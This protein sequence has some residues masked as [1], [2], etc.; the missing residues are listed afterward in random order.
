MSPRLVQIALLFSLAYG[1]VTSNVTCMSTFG[2]AS[3]I[4]F[5]ALTVADGLFRL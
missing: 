5:G 3:F 1:Q 2:W 4:V